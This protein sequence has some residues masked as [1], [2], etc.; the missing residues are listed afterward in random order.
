MSDSLRDRPRVPCIYVCQHRSCQQN[1]SEET[2]QAFRDA[3]P[4]GVVVEKCGCLGQCSTGP[5][6]RVTRDETWYWQVKADDV[7]RIIEEHI[8]GGEPVADKL[9][10]RIHMRFYV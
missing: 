4:E 10:T 6:V 2:L 1:G 8:E 9:N 5:S 7:P 3:N